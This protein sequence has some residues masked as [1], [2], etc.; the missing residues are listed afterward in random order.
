[1]VAAVS[2][3]EPD[4]A[5]VA[6]PPEPGQCWAPA[7]ARARAR[8]WRRH[9]VGER[10]RLR[11]ATAPACRR[12]TAAG[13][14]RPGGAGRSGEPVGG[15]S[16]PGGVCPL[17]PP[18]LPSQPLEACC[19]TVG[20]G[21]ARPAR[22]RAVPGVTLPFLATYA[23]FY[24]GRVLVQTSGPTPDNVPSVFRVNWK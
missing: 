21:A 11:W 12:V 22:A 6:V 19:E 24:A 13:P 8:G 23:R 1:E 9:R 7:V 4:M 2:V 18:P 16:V 15:R 5:A 17:P 14:T 10:R 20:A 3:R